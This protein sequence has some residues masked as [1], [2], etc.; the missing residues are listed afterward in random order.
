M[1]VRVS[2]P[3]ATGLPP[4]DCCSSTAPD[5]T[6]STTLDEGRTIITVW[7]SAKWLGC[8]AQLMRYSLDEVILHD[9]GLL[10]APLPPACTSPAGR[11]PPPGLLPCSVHSAAL[12]LSLPLSLAPPKSGSRRRNAMIP[13]PP[14]PPAHG[15]LTM[16]S[17]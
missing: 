2:S 5:R 11:E 13:S 15:A 4:S 14:S 6:S 9:V 12:P 7:P 16:R 1:E 8:S 10:G 17:R 3:G